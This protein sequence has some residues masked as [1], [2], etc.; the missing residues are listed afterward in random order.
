MALFPRPPGWAG[1][2]RELLD[3]MMQG[4][5]NRGR[6]T[7]QRAGSHSIR[8]NQCPPPPSSPYFLQAG[9]PSCRPTNSIKALKIT[10]KMAVKMKVSRRCYR[11]SILLL[12]VNQVCQT[13]KTAGCPSL[14][15]SVKARFKAL[16][17]CYMEQGCKIVLLLLVVALYITS[18]IAALI[19]YRMVSI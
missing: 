7:D 12:R 1:A 10:W 3:F 9:C 6:H 2:R 13:L 15:A 11:F 5:I 17:P 18:N 4:K 16:S 8:T 19:V 14:W